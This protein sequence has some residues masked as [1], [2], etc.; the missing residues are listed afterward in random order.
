MEISTATTITALSSLY[1]IALF[2]YRHCLNRVR[3]AS[4]IQK[5]TLL[6]PSRS[7]KTYLYQK[8][9]SQKNYM[10]ID[11]DEFM[12]TCSTPEEIERL[13]NAKKNNSF[14]EYD[15]YYKAT[16]D[17]VLKFIREQIKANRKLK[18]LFLTSCYNWS[19]QF[20]TDSVCVAS[21]NSEYWD[22]ILSKVENEKEKEHLRK[23]RQHFLDSL[24]S[25][26]A[27]CTYNSLSELENLVRE[28]LNLKYHL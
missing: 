5:H 11:V 10:I 28:R 16:A 4:N 14:Y 27:V 12:K 6:I 3:K 21:P 1:P 23:Y 22:K 25:Q 8:L 20:K 7:G 18:V 17:K 13:T 19:L 9:A 15:L 2:T 24:P 26:N